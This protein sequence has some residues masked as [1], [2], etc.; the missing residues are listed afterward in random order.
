MKK[1]GIMSMQ[2]IKNYGSFLQAYG[3]KK[4]IESLGYSTCFVDYKYE[5]SI[6][7]KS[8]SSFYNNIIIKV[9][10]NL[11]IITFIRRRN[12]NK[13]WNTIFKTDIKKYLN[14]TDLYYAYNDIDELV[15]GSDEVFN[16]L[17]GYPVGYSR[18]LFGK[19]YENIPVISYGGCFGNATLERIKEYKIDNEIGEMLSKFKSISV[20]DKNSYNIVYE[21]TKI[22]PSIN[23]DP[24]LITDFSN[25]T[26]DNV[27]IKNYILIYAYP[28]R[29]TKE[30]CKYIVDFAKSK[31]KKIVSIG[32]FQKIADYNLAIEPFEIFSYF[33]HA[34]FVITDTFHGT[35]FSIKTHS[36][37][38][39]IIRSGK[40]GN[41]NKLEDLL[42]RV[43]KK[44][45]I[46]KNIHD[47]SYM[48]EKNTDFTNVDKILKY[49][50]EKSI[51]YLK[52]NLIK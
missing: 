36:N 48:Y 14:I 44:N 7:E 9:K 32:A 33:K 12:F 51:E 13:K 30:E 10:R 1:I 37:F 38:A 26:I 47:I 6:I 46:I 43:G 49:E 28:G 16:C 19:N 21:L 5:K 52:N 24:V 22:A 25:E 40:K 39:T 27:K 20:R 29:L 3:L 4:T 42:E 31:K 15:I 50:T 34:D 18:E 41:N 35:I 45:N 17:Q 11:N 2:R 23:L 8:E